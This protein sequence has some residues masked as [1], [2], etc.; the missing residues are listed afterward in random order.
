ML[1]LRSVLGGG[2]RTGFA[3]LLGITLGCV[4]WATASIAGLTALLAASTIA[5]DVLRFAGAAYLIWLGGSALWRYRKG[6]APAGLDDRRTPTSVVSALRTGLL[7]NLLNPKVGVF[8]LS[9][10][11]QF[12]PTTGSTRWAVLLVAIHLAAGAIWSTA[13]IV[14]AGRAR[15]LLAREAVKLWLERA[16][17]GILL[18][19]GLRIA[20]E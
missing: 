5:Y 11:P 9:L 12:L 3:S 17:A 19:F 14:L 6:T 7:T 15:V 2:R 10:L 4:V 20:L 16:T 1:I 8:Y 13:V 18:A